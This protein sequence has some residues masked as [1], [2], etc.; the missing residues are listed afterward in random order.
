MGWS[1]WIGAFLGFVLTLLIFSYLIGD[2]PLFRIT[3][4]IFIGVSAGFAAVIA[5]ENIILPRL[6]DPLFSSNRGEQVLALIPLILA[7]LL[8]FKIS[9]RFAF[10]GNL[11]VSYLVGVSAAAAIGGA[12][13]GTL[14]PQVIASINLLDL[15]P[16]PVFDATLGLHLLNGIIILVGT[17]ATLAYFHF[18]IGSES[19]E[20][21]QIQNWIEGLGQI[22]QVFIA[23]TFG[24]LFAGI[25]SA[26]LTAL[27]GRV[28]FSVDF[29]R[30]IIGIFI[31]N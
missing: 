17:I 16:N 15:P 31:V 21:S 18:G 29:L 28:V 23:I 1:D 30:S 11:P 24:F 3:V 7:V 26:A 4:H 9:P 25:L 13:T 14:I 2:N 20:K 27:I 8:L 22:G 6:I 10:I 5:I 12:V 19:T